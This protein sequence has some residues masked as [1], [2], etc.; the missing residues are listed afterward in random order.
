MGDFPVEVEAKKDNIAA[1]LH[2]LCKSEP[3]IQQYTKA[4]LN[5]CWKMVIQRPQMTF[6]VK[7]KYLGDSFH[8]LHW[9][10][11]QPDTPH[12]LIHVYPLL[13]HG[14]NLMKKGKVLL[15]PSA[16]GKEDSET[17]DDL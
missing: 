7:D 11:V 1:K 17:D 8:N 12:K 16:A 15:I 4:C 2:S 13:Y 9:N 10:S 3:D 6:Q 5:F 14:K